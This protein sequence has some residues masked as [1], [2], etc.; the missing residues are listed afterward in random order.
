MFEC[1]EGECHFNINDLCTSDSFENQHFIDPIKTLLESSS[2]PFL[3][4]VKSWTDLI[5]YVLKGQFIQDIPVGD[6]QL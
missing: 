4:K 2:S 3:Q 6:A 1:P 5:Y